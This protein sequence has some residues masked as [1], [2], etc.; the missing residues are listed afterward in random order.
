MKPS[1]LQWRRH[2]ARRPSI[3]DHWCLCVSLDRVVS[4][5]LAG[6]SITFLSEPLPYPSACRYGEHIP[7][8]WAS[9]KLVT[10]LNSRDTHCCLNGNWL[11]PTSRSP[12]HSLLSKDVELRFQ[13]NGQ[14]SGHRAA[15]PNLHTRRAQLALLLLIVWYKSVSGALKEKKQNA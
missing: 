14:Q 12:F 4:A 1:C 5:P 13:F 3:H 8:G 7:L 9:R 6:V 15:M 11:V 10:T 2:T